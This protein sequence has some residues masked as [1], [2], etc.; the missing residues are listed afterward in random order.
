MA[1]GHKAAGALRKEARLH[2]EQHLEEACAYALAIRTFALKSLQSILRKRP[3]KRPVLS[4][5]PIPLPL[6]KT[7]GVPTIFAPAKMSSSGRRRLPTY[8]LE[9]GGSEPPERVGQNHWNKVS[10]SPAPTF[11][12]CLHHMKLGWLV[13]DC[14]G[15]VQRQRRGEQRLRGLGTQPAWRRHGFC[16]RQRCNGGSDW[17]RPFALEQ[18]EHEDSGSEV[19]RPFPGRAF[20]L[21]PI[22]FPLV[23]F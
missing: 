16:K 9:Q 17:R 19:G 1:N 13:A 2:G 15:D 12:A 6:T 5:Q 22:P 11:T 18:P 8:S 20:A 10:E 14:L 4:A 7:C 3:D 23:A 21:A